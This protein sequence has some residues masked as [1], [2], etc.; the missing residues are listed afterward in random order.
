MLINV[1]VENNIQWSY[2]VTFSTSGV[3]VVCVSEPANDSNFM[4]H[5]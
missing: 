5:I 1:V 4:M 3:I 2:T